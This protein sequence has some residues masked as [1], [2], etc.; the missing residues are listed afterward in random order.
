MGVAMARTEFGL[1]IMHTYDS[2][3]WL[4]NE[5]QSWLEYI[6]P[7]KVMP[8]LTVTLNGWQNNFFEAIMQACKSEEQRVY[9]IRKVQEAD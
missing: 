2:G 7:G 9:A 1:E 6:G 4:W 8:S 5:S 3:R